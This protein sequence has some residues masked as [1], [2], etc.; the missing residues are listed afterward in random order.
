MIRLVIL[1]LVR[2][3]QVCISPFLPKNC[4]FVPTC[5]EYAVNLLKSKKYNIFKTIFTIIKRI[6]RCQN[7]GNKQ[8]I[9]HDE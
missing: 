7:L 2:L 3:Y 1:F 8:E 9:T 6:G 4:I 5:S